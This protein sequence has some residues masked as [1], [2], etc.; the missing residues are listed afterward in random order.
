MKVS[1]RGV[2]RIVLLTKNYAIKFPRFD[3]GWRLFIE[4]IR[5]NLNE[6]E[7]WMIANIPDNDLTTIKQYLCPIIW[8]SWGAW[9]VVMK[10]ANPIPTQRV[11]T[12]R[13]NTIIDI[14][15]QYIGDQKDDNYGTLNGDI[16]MFDYGCTNV[17]YFSGQKDPT[18]K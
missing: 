1:R 16:V 7:I 15:R 3:Y 5:A 10:R 12:H 6:R 2:T 9:I 11:W 8:T 4:G 13:L 17:D 18:Y 14:V